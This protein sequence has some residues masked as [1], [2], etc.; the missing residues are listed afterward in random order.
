MHGCSR[1]RCAAR[2]TAPREPVA[3]SWSRDGADWPNR[4]LSAFVETEANRWHVQR[5]GSGPRILLL[6][7]AGAATHSWRDVIPRLLP[8]FEIMAPDLPGQ[9]FSTGTARRFTLPCMAAD[10]R[11]LLAAEDFDPQM[12]VGHSAGGAIALRMALDLAPSPRHVLCLNGAL[13]PFSG[14]AGV[15]FP[16]LAKLLSLNPL[17]ASLFARTAGAP[18]AVRNLIEG[19]GS[20]IDARGLA[21][22]RRLV[23]D[24]GHVAAT[25]AMM[26]RWDLDPLIAAL[27]RLAP[28]VT[29]ALGER[30]RAVPPQGA[31]RLAP[32]IPDA[33][34]IAFPALGHLMHEEAPD[35]IAALIAQVASEPDCG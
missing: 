22:Y 29:L 28:C 15:V 9:G 23:G 14:M 2:S 10:L 4:E 6:H 19:T 11:R 26:A 8:R 13:T 25:L 7:G 5:G 27:P 18:G 24:A 33:R 34:L 3:L 16:P 17:T 20:R 31:R 12:I 21:L 35:E 30:D 32:R 1:A